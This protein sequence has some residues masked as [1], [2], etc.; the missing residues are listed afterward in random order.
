MRKPSHA[1]GKPAAMDTQAGG[2]SFKKMKLAAHM[3]HGV[4]PVPACVEAPN[5]KIRTQQQPTPGLCA[6]GQEADHISD[7][8]DALLGEIISLLPIKD[9]ARTKILA[10]RWSHLWH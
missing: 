7:L 1:L 2:P 3:S 4:L 10:S 9:G 6:A 8:P 5:T